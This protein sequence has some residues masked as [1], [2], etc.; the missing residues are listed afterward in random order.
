MFNPIMLRHELSGVVV[1]LV[2]VIITAVAEV[3]LVVYTVPCHWLHTVFDT[4]FLQACAL[5]V[6]L[7]L[8]FSLS[9]AEELY[10]VVLKY[11]IDVFVLATRS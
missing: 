5:P 3:S 1:V 2:V 10:A 8:Q 7:D 6:I 4:A 11:F 9:H